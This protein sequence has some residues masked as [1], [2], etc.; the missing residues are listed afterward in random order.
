MGGQLLVQGLKTGCS[1]GGAQALDEGL[2]K[3]LSPARMHFGA[4][5]AGA[6][7]V[8]LGEMARIHQ[9]NDLELH[10]AALDRHQEKHALGVEGGV[11]LAPLTG[12]GH[13]V[14]QA[15]GGVIE[16]ALV[17]H[18]PGAANRLSKRTEA[19]TQRQ[20]RKQAKPAQGLKQRRPKTRT[21]QL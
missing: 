7:E 9:G 1:S 3:Q 18:T 4:F 11:Q 10:A 20:H 13:A 2:I 16:V 12:L 5:A 14:Q 17:A 6:I 8:L 21:E 15:K 19:P